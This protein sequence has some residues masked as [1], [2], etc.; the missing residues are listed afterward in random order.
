MLIEKFK[1]EQSNNI[2]KFIPKLNEAKSIV[3]NFLRIEFLLKIFI[4]KIKQEPPMFSAIKVNGQPLYKFARKG[5][6][7]RRKK[8]VISIYD[9]ELIDNSQDN[10]TLKVTCGRGTYIRSLAKDIAVKLNT[11]GHLI[12][13]KRTRIGEYD[14]KNCIKVEDFPKW[15]SART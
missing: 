9:I 14:N 12:T 5:I 2:F 15:I 3:V 8:K 10:L 6:N 1:T 11:V 13:L 7:I 4:G